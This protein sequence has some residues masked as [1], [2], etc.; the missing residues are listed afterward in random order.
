MERAGDHAVVLGASIA[1]LLSARVLADAYQRVTI[2]ERDP[3]PTGESDRKGVPQGRHSG[4]PT[5]P[6]LPRSPG[7]QTGPRPRQRGTA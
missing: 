2:V 3:L 7:S 4:L 6:P 1:G 5:Q